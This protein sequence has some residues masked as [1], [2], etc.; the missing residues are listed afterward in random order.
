M[1]YF[2]KD[3]QRSLRVR[4]F[5]NPLIEKN[6]VSANVPAGLLDKDTRRAWLADPETKYAV[7][8][9]W[10]GT[11][12]VEVVNSKNGNPPAKMHGLI[13]DYD[14]P[15]P[16]P[17]DQ[18]ENVLRTIY[19]DSLDLL[20]TW[21]VVSPSG[22][23]RLV[24]EFAQPMSVAGA[25]AP[26]LTAFLEE[27]RRT[28]KLGHLLAGLDESFTRPHVYYD[29]GGD[30]TQ[31][32]KKPLDADLI[33]SALVRATSRVGKIK[34]GPVE[35]PM[36]AVKAEID[37]R[38]PGKWP[39]DID[40]KDGCL[41]PA[42][43]HPSAKSKHTT[44][45]R[46]WGVVCFSA[47]GNMVKPY[48]EIL[49][50]GFTKKWE[51]NRIGSAV[52]NI[53]YLPKV[54]YYRKFEDS[55]WRAAPKEDLSLFLAG[56]KG[57]SRMKGPAQ[58]LSEVESAL[59]HL[60]RA[61]TVDGAVPFVFDRREVVELS[62]FKFLNTARVSCMDPD[63]S[64][65]NRRWAEDFPFTGEWLWKLFSTKRELVLF[66]AWLRHF[67]MG[68]Y[69]GD[70]TRGLAVFF[71]GGTNIGKTLLNAKW[72]PWMVGGGTDPSKHIIQGEQFNRN[73]LEVAHWHIDDAQA[74]TDRK[75]LQR[76]SERVKALVANPHIDYRPMYSDTQQ[77]PFNGRILV[78]LNGDEVSLQ[79]LPDMDM[80]IADKLL[81]LKGAD[82]PGFK[83]KKTNA[84]TERTLRNELPA[85]LGWLHDWEP[86]ERVSGDGRRF[87]T[88]DSINP[89]VRREAA[90]T[91]F[92]SDILGLFE[93]LWGTDDEWIELAKQDKPWVGTAA[94][95][96]QVLAAHPSMGKLM[97]GLTV[98]GVGM[99]L[100]KLARVSG[101]GVAVAKGSKAKKESAHY[102]I[103][104]L[105]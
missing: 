20:P 49:G 37:E 25:P 50:K 64:K 69:T 66:L 85:F 63:L 24:W 59:L 60:Q 88:Q 90:M 74:A 79:M 89:L 47:D 15:A 97:S 71:V 7:I 81:I 42:V 70:L 5:A 13:V 38:F 65:R 96:I 98:R 26:L 101:T 29:I 80:N 31:C 33:R 61:C 35:I 73:L 18:I 84:E 43:W 91:S 40:F 75:Q 104:K 11:N 105:T 94:Q 16:G 100:A 99:R 34:G 28:F 68:C 17:A 19:H 83:F 6:N 78:T 57:L 67:Y 92:D 39:K 62:N 53:Y 52:E 86:S 2:A 102:E 4:T 55:H 30:W 14:S 51:E 82:D 41:G 44:I 1:T 76:F 27:L 8:S 58:G 23:S 45:W 87:G 32:S 10:E 36:E 54:G 72:I 46:T 103:R 56:V 48:A 9:V 22:N 21:I 95:I 93:I 77:I 12:P 3:N